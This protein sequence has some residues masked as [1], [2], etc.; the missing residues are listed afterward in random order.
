MI[1]PSVGKDVRL[2]IRVPGHCIP[3]SPVSVSMVCIIIV[4]I[5]VT[6]MSLDFDS[7]LIQSL[8]GVQIELRIMNTVD[9]R[10]DSLFRPTTIIEKNN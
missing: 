5:P 3:W 2:L 1:I 7:W 10:F 6:T 9:G 4:W 8:Y